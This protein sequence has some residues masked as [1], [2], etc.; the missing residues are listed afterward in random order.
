[1]D[2]I[3]LDHVS[4]RYDNGFVAVDNVSLEIAKGEKV[5][6]IGQNGAGRRQR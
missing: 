1:M 2:G 4:F 5:A 6:I 3:S